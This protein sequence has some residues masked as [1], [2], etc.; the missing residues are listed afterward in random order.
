MME[1]RIRDLLYRS[2]DGDLSPD[3]REDLDTALAASAELRRERDDALAVRGLI[4]DS[5]ERSFGPFFAER[6]VNTIRS[7]R[8]GEAAGAPFF[9]SLLH[10]F[11]R[12]A[13]AA[14]AVAAFLLIYNLN[15]GGSL[16]VAAAFGTGGGADIEE[17][18][19]APVTETLE[20]LL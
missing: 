3:E 6:V 17:V 20:E 19:T 7:E 8:E 13:I 14:A 16:S 10:A 2:L 18:L 12:V 1:D 9:E 4:K 5:A 15:Q 11:R